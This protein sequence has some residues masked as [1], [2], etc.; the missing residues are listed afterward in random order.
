MQSAEGSQA[1]ERFHALAAAAVDEF[2]L[3][4]P[5][6]A[7]HLG[8]HRSDAALT[9]LDDA[10]LAA[11]ARTCTD[12]LEELGTIDANELSAQDAVD[13]AML[14]TAL[15]QRVF[16][17][18][19]LAE[20][21]WNPLAY[22][23]GEGLYPLLARTERPA[24]ERLRALA[25]RLA[26]VPDRLAT[27]RNQ[28]DNPPAVHVETAIGQAAGAAHLIDVEIPAA[29]AGEPGMRGEVEPVRVAASAALDSYTAW[30]RT[31]L[32]QGRATGEYR[33]GA[34][35][36]ARKLALALDAELSPE[37]IVAAA[38]ENLA[39]T[40][41]QLY[42]LARDAF[43]APAASDGH[44][45]RAAIAQMLDSIGRDHPDDSSI[46][47]Q[48]EAALA[49]ATAFV[50]EHELVTLIDQRTA[51][52][53][54]PEF[55]RGVA[56]AY[57]DS[58][59]PLEDDGVTFFAIAPTPRDWPNERKESFYREY[60]DALVVDLTVH[61]AMPGHMLQLAHARSFAGT[62]AVRKVFRSGSFIEGW[63]VH[64]ERIMAEL[65][66]GG[67]AVRAQQ[68]KMQLRMSINTILDHGV[69]AGG[70]SESE[71]MRLMTTDGFQEEGEAAGK[72]RRAC[73]TSTQLSTYF[74]GYVELAALL[75]N[76]PTG[77]SDRQVH[78]ELLAHGNPSP[79]RLRQLLGWQNA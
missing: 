28:L 66:H 4:H 68:L 79:R 72:W 29:L 8:D 13:H 32:D 7:T 31:L 43:D 17:H 6:T 14:T 23:V 5:E 74:V 20:H 44:G 16:A 15:Q 50:E 75:T 2:L 69:H 37:E 22:N 76:R 1:T 12:R 60:N 35:R 46:V 21:T 59:G 34:D 49:V 51:I 27:A 11:V 53:E 56:V 18:E 19:R 55:R 48:A 36:F 39:A 30:L 10:S 57:C 78:D 62:T 9:A 24:A 26:G 61:E 64:A 33:I 47:G 54:M 63:A 65:G 67:P 40:T 41:E 25:G 77:W 3:A 38:R 52:V 73:L 71:A 45:R 42:A 70:M 58:P